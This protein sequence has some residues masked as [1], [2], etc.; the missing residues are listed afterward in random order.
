MRK[1]K[2][3]KV[4]VKVAIK[5]CKEEWGM[6]QGLGGIFGG[7]AEYTLADAPTSWYDTKEGV[8]SSA[9]KIELSQKLFESLLTAKKHLAAEKAKGDDA[10]PEDVGYLY[11]K[12]KQ[13]RKRLAEDA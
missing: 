8:D 11:R 3:A 9:A 10:N 6:D 1:E 13:I 7:P 12:V 4:A 5:A 2:E